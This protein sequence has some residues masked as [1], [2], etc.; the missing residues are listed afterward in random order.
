MPR[1]SELLEPQAAVYVLFSHSEGQNSDDYILSVLE[2]QR[3]ELSAGIQS[4]ASELIGS[5]VRVQLTPPVR[6]SVEVGILIYMAVFTT[7]ADW[8]RFHRNLATFAKAV[9]RFFGRRFGGGGP[10]PF[11]WT[12]AYATPA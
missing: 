12:V 9:A 6:G 8:D 10:T 4:L 2:E 11:G 3:A 7:L 1:A 5:E